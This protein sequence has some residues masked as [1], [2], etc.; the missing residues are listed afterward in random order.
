MHAPQAVVLATTVLPWST[1]DVCGTLS[2]YR[3][4][5]FLPPFLGG[6]GKGE[7]MKKEKI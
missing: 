6:Y 4:F 5:L 2:R 7:D 1:P 3:L